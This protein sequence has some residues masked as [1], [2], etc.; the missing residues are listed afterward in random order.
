MSSSLPKYYFF[1]GTLQDPS[2]LSRV[3][4]NTRSTP[5]LLIPAKITGYRTKLWA[6]RYPALVPAA[7]DAV[8]HGVAY[9]VT[10]ADERSRLEKYETDAYVATECVIELEGELKEGEWEVREW[11]MRVVF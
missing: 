4:G 10:T 11:Q 6:G 9:E 3:L 2:T 1:Y 8:V 5:R 7:Q